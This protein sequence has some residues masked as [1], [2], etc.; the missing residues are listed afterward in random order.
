[1]KTFTVPTIQ[2]QAPLVVSFTTFQ[3]CPEQN[4]GQINL[5][6]SGG[7]PPYSYAWSDSPQGVADIRTQLMAGNYTSTI[8]DYCGAQVV[9]S[10]PLTPMTVSSFT[11]TPGC[12]NQGTGNIQI[13]NGNP[14][15]SYAWNTNPPQ[16][17]ANTQNLRNGTICVTVTDNRGCV[18]TQCNDLLNKQYRI[19][20]ENLP[21]EGFND[22]SLKLKVYNPLAE[23]VQINL[24]G[25]PMPIL[26][27]FATEVTQQV[28]NLASDANYSLAVTIG[29]CSYTYPFTMQHKPVNYVYDRYNNNICYYDVYCGPNLI[30]NDG[31]QSPPRMNFNGADGSWLTKCYVPTVCG[32]TEVNKVQ[33]TKRTDKALV[34]YLVL[35]DALANSPHSSDYVNARI[36]EYNR[37]GLKSCDFVRWCPASLKIIGTIPGTNGTYSGSGDCYKLDCKW[38]VK[39]E[40]FCLFN[41]VPDYFFSSINPIIPNPPAQYN[42]Q[43]RVY[44]LYELI[45]WKGDLLAKFPN[46]F[47]GTEL[48]NLISYWELVEPVDQRIYCAT[49]G[50]CLTDFK[51]L[52]DN[53]WTIDCSSCESSDYVYYGPD[54]E[55][56]LPCSP[57]EGSSLTKVYCK[58]YSFCSGGGGCCLFPVFLRNNFPGEFLIAPSD[59]ALPPFHTYQQ[60]PHRTDEFVNFGEA[61]ADSTFIPKGLFKNKHG[62]GLYYDYFPH[63]TSAERE[64]IPNIKLSVEDFDENILA[65]ISKNDN[66]PIYYLGY[67]DD[68]QDWTV[69]IVSSGFLE[70]SHLS[71]EDTLLVVACQYQGALTFG[72]LQIA[73]STSIGAIILRVSNTGTVVTTRKVEN[74]DTNQPLTF[75]RSGSNLMISGRTGTTALGTNGQ[76]AIQGS[77][78]G[79]YFTL[80]DHVSDATYQYQSNLL[81]VSSGMTLLKTTYSKLTGNRTYL[82]AGSGTVQINSQTIAQPSSNQLTLVTLTPVGALVWVNTVN[83]ASYYPTELDLTEG[84]NGS[85]FLGLTFIDTLTASNQTAVSNGGKDVAILKYGINGLLTGIKSFGSLDDEEVKRCMFTGGNLYFGG[86][87]R[88]LTFERLIGNNIY[89]SYPSDSVYCKAYITYLPDSTFGTSMSHRPVADEAWIKPVVFTADVYVR[90]NPFTDKIQVWLK[91]NIMAEHTVQL[92]NALGVTVWIR[93][94]AVTEGENVLTINDLEPLPVG[95]YALRVLVPD[96]Q[97]YT[98]KMLKQ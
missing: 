12:E 35:Y 24:D 97:I 81:N 7:I 50:F 77:Q 22:G 64:T 69:P 68:L 47:P 54:E 36:G 80:Q 55:P 14:G 51:V 52:F 27:P 70:I 76:T 91:S 21:C 58:N 4:N 20:E 90:P 93:K 31:H 41:K 82:F 11:L 67:E 42:C 78:P 87:Y 65:Y 88:G 13:V 62:N 48:Y 3:P 94:V 92:V 32:D 89:E 15:Y 98:Y 1:M 19:I 10:I 79:Q 33:Y 56:P 37:K 60:L 8:T 40:D 96:G 59:D 23:L 9:T 74:F 66:E 72:S 29:T 16:S 63:T 17:G 86:N 46:T 6:V 34:Y 18:L 39:D 84:D 53:I 73:N 26:N 38:P 5:T 57:E 25:Q 85:M 43:P 83:V 45:S 30:A 61:Y 75:E 71:R 2:P 28:P 95:I 49:V 44:S